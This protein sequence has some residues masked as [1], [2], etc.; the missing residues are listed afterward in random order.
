MRYLTFAIALVF[1]AYVPAMGQG[2]FTIDKLK[3]INDDERA[4]LRK[5]FNLQD[6][7]R[8]TL[9]E[10]KALPAGTSLK[11]CVENIVDP[12]VRE[13]FTAWVTEWNNKEVAK[14]G[15]LEIV[16]DS[17]QAD[18]TILRYLRP[19]PSSDPINAMTYTDPKGKTHRLIPVYSYFLV[20][21]TDSLEI[22][23]RKVDLTYPEEAEVST[24]LLANELKK[25]LKDRTKTQ[26]K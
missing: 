10:S 8:I 11:V 23:W 15:A 25:R 9:D 17:T 12:K 2:G 19:L 1:V 26:K 14:Y 24:K 5:G 18:V 21:R 6:S 20:R 4:F 7:A 13:S 22:L 16:P 3:K